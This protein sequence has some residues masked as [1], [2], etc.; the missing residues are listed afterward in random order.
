[1]PLDERSKTVLKEIVLSYI[2]TALPVG[3]TTIT[4]RYN[5]GVG[6][7]TIRNIMADLEEAGF[8]AQPHTSAGRIPT[9]KGYRFYVDNLFDE[10]AFLNHK[11]Q[12]IQDAGKLVKREDAAT[13]LQD[14]TKLL[15]ELSQYM[16][17]VTAPKFSSAPIRHCEFVRLSPKA[18]M[19]IA[20]SEA[21]FVQN[22]FFEI[23]KDL[24]QKEL[25]RISDY[26]NSLYEGMSFADIRKKLKTQM[27]KMQDLYDYL[28]TE[29]FELTKQAMKASVNEDA[30]KIYMDGA[31]QM[32]DLPDFSDFKVMKGLLKAFNEKKVIIQLLD[33]FIGSEGV[34]VFIGAEN[35]FLG[36]DQ[37][38][39]VLSQ[40]K[41]GDRVLGAL[42]VIGPTRMEYSK[43]IPLVDATAKQVSRLLES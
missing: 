10:K 21:G 20:V 32:L 13:L 25:N 11:K 1:M 19:A 27:V 37:C 33:K 42:G 39:M 22:K 30:G 2:K 12:I 28:Q 41:Q 15:S 38:S 18:I 17:I 40:Y 16:A 3:S 6:P 23:S 31:A 35:Q 5:F 26:L 7:A 34:Q 24:N 4:K 43:V 14:T 9:E 29:A 8:L 36:N